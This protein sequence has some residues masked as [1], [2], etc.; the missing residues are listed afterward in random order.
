MVI[1]ESAA[2]SFGYANP[3]DIIGKNFEQWGR[4]GTIV[5]VVKDFN[6]LSLHQTVAPLTLRYS[7][8][9]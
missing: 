6:Y 1:N 8:Y 7:Q 3:A 9:G 2:R 4:E 5:G